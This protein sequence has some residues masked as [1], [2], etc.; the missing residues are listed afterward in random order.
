[1]SEKLEEILAKMAEKSE[2][3]QAQITSLLTAIQGMPGINDPIRVTVQPAA[4]VQ[5]LAIGLRKSN[6]VKDFKHT[7]D[8]NIRTY[9]KKFDEEIKS[10][11]SMVGI[12]NDLSKEEYVPLFRASLDF[13]VLK[14]VEQVFK[15]DPNNL[16]TWDT[17]TIEALH[18][19]MIDE[20][21]IKYTDVANVLGQFGPSRLSKSADK[22][23]SEFYY[24]WFLQIPEIMKPTSN[25]EYKNFADLVHR[26]MFYISLNDKFLQ[27][28]LSDLKEPNPTLKTYLDEAI[29]AESRRKCFNDIAV[30]SSSLDSSGGSLFQNGTL[31]ICKIRSRT[32]KS[33]MFQR[34]VSQ[35]AT[36]SLISQTPPKTKMLRTQKQAKTKIK[37][38]M[39]VA[40]AKNAK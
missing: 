11:K 2:Q 21:G 30:S 4:Q 39:L 35:R 8:S 16:K 23:V 33:Q 13:N 31:L 27:Q 1:M 28:A 17:I 19:L 10:L 26:A 7:K 32:Q 14:R 36:K 37:T 12:A 24:D 25:A 15:V 18:K 6:R 40:I 5:R 29:A 38:K 20:F 9:I 3:Q 22:S 34:E